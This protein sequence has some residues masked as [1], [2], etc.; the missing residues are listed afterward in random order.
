MERPFAIP[1]RR[2]DEATRTLS[3][4]AGRDDHPASP[5]DARA[6][7]KL[8]SAGCVRLQLADSLIFAMRYVFVTIDLK[9][10]SLPDSGPCYREPRPTF[11]AGWGSVPLKVILGPPQ[12]G[13]LFRGSSHPRPGMPRPRA[14]GLAC[15]FG[16][17]WR[18]EAPAGQKC[19]V[20]TPHSESALAG[21][22]EPTRA[23]L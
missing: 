15:A 16:G 17:V 21:S 4:R 14:A 5:V 10:W 1:L 12:L 8:A 3:P 7:G 9:P 2:Q 20:R 18:G 11:P 23:R 19:A 6:V 22:V 13:G